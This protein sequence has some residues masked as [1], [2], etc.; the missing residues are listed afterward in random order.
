MVMARTQTLIQMSDDLLARLDARA[1]REHR[2]RSEVVREAI[3]AYLDD[4]QEAEI[5][6]Q[7]VEAYTRIPQTHDEV[8]W[9]DASVETLL[10]AAGPWDE[11]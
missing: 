6:R 5:D 4:D 7:I 1:A 9:A 3:S 8:A 11:A 2:N 10:D